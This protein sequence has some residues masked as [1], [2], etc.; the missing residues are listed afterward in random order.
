MIYFIGFFIH[1]Y[2]ARSGASFFHSVCHGR[3]CGNY[4]S[5]TFRRLVFT[6]ICICYWESL[7]FHTYNHFV[8]CKDTKKNLRLSL[9]SPKN[10]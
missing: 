4:A 1:I 3:F 8:A 5:A 10:I 2:N 7:F 9:F 6:T